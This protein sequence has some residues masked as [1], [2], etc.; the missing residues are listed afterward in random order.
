MLHTG[1]DR[2]DA[3]QVGELIKDVGRL[4]PADYIL[5]IP[6]VAYLRPDLNI[7]IRVDGI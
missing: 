1:A 2:G 3:F 6:R 4:V 7:Y 5:N